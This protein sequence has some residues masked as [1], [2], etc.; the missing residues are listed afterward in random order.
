MQNDSADA[1][2]RGESQSE[3]LRKKRFK[4]GIS[5][6]SRGQLIVIYVMEQNKGIYC[7][8][9]LKVKKNNIKKSYQQISDIWKELVP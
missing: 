5:Q 9:I 1:K 2:S 8:K 3:W 4:E 7:I 6:L